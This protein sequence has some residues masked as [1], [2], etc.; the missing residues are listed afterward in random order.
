ML[1]VRYLCAV[2]AVNQSDVSLEVAFLGE[3]SVR[4]Q[5]TLITTTDT[6]HHQPV[7]VTVCV[8]SAHVDLQVGF[9][10]EESVGALQ[11]LKGLL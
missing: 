11:A 2:V 3:H 7:S 8:V 4:T 5:L 9:R 1:T 10:G 6:L